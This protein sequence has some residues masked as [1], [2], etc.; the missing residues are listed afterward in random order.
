MPRRRWRGSCG[1]FRSGGA[2]ALTTELSL[3]CRCLRAV[4]VPSIV[5]LEDVPIYSR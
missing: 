5:R 1:S 4:F 3:K 2:I